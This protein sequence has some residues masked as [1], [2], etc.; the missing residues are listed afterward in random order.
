MHTFTLPSGPEIALAEMTGA[1][2]D[3]LTDQRLA[4]TGEAVNQVLAN[5]L[6]RVGDNEAPG[7]KDILD[8]L[9]GDRLFALVYLRQVSLGDEVELDLACP[10]PACGERRFTK[11]LGQVRPATANQDLR[12]LHAAFQAGVRRG[13]LAKNPFSGLKPV[14]EPEK[15]LRVLSNEE[16]GRLLAA[17]HNLT[18][19]TFVFVAVSTGLRR[20]ELCYLEW[21]DLDLEAGLMLVRNKAEHRTKSARNRAVALVPGAVELLRLLSRHA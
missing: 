16:V 11:R 3:L 19:R 9:S 15:T 12:T 8:M 7:M 1:E 10:N 18:W 14:R 6:K 4:K 21:E 5:C 20:G 17:C 2:D 13:C